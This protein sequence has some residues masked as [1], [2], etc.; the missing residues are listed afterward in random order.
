MAR[1]NPANSRKA[2]IRYVIDFLNQNVHILIKKGFHSV[3]TLKAR[4]KNFKKFTDHSEKK[5][6]KAFHF[7]TT[8]ETDTLDQIQK[9][10]DIPVSFGKF[11]FE[12]EKGNVEFAKFIEELQEKKISQPERNDNE[13]Q[14]INSDQLTED[15][16]QIYVKGGQWTKPTFY[17]PT[18][19]ILILSS[20]FFYKY[21]IAS[22]YEINVFTQDNLLFDTTA[23][24]YNIL[25]LPFQ[26]L[27]KPQIGKAGIENTIITRLIDMNDKD[28]LNLQIKFDTIDHIHGYAQ[29]EALGKKLHA[30]LAI[31]GDFYEN[32]KSE[33]EA[34]LKFINISS[35][36]LVL[37]GKEKGDSGIEKM[38][39]LSEVMQGKLQKDV[40]Y[41]IYWVAAFHASDK[42]DYMKALGFFVKIERTGNVTDQ[43]FGVMA[44]YYFILECYDQ[45]EMY[46]EKAIQ[47]NSSDAIYH[48]NYAVL[49]LQRSK[50]KSKAKEEF[51]RALQIDSNIVELQVDYANILYAE[52][53]EKDKAKLHY[54]K[55]LQIDSKNI[56]LRNNYATFLE[57]LYDNYE[58][59]IK[60]L[61]AQLKI[62]SN[63]FDAQDYLAF[64]LA[65]KTKD[66]L[67]AKE[68]YEMAIKIN[69][70]NAPSHLNY[71]NLLF[72]K[73]NDSIG[74]KTNYESA[75]AINP[76]FA[77]AHFNYALLLMKK[78]RKLNEARNQYLIAIREDP[79]FKNKVIEMCLGIK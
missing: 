43:L 20:F 73:F 22:S 57:R 64:L 6:F 75:I 54:Q 61:N 28:K 1:E 14:E 21:K 72:L 3:N 71:A 66:S 52:F 15:K 4:E 53:G 42:K 60:Y 27:G 33:N 38:I 44:G 47:L 13:K 63:D 46:Y 67:G 19:C 78:F 36:N 2:Y 68:H 77:Y 32:D 7:T 30:H 23:G 40:D 39:S 55:A 69:P 56:M 31:W 34:C 65:T 18:F 16:E 11:E 25:L 62:N 70:N 9:A 50:N 48:M 10:F 5:F 74:A 12:L 8:P 17:V 26:S 41:I 37:G 24:S 45:S 51:E 58:D 59:A 79:T 49:L 35:K 76:K 29:A